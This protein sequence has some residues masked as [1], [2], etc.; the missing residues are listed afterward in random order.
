MSLSYVRILLNNCNYFNLKCVIVNNR[1]IEY[2]CEVIY[3]HIILFSSLGLSFHVLNYRHE[4]L[5]EISFIREM[6]C[7]SYLERPAFSK[8]SRLSA[9]L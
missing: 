6:K 9:G 4:I 5:I 7:S 2:R 1:M 3:I 8:G